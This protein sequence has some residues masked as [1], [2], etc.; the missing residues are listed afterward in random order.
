MKSGCGGTVP[1]V[2]AP[3]VLPRAASGTTMPDVL[4][5]LVDRARVALV[6][7]HRLGLRLHVRD[8][9]RLAGR[10]RALDGMLGDGR[11]ILAAELDHELRL[12]GVDVPRAH[13]AQ[14]A[15]VVEVDGHVAGELRDGD[16][17]ERAERMLDVERRVQQLARARQEAHPAFGDLRLRDVADRR[18][19]RAPTVACRVLDRVR[20]NDRP[21]LLARRAVA[22]ADHA[23]ARLAAQRAAAGKVVRRRAGCR[24][25]RA[26]RSARAPRSGRRRG[27][28]RRSRSR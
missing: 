10:D 5:E 8:E 21:A 12:R 23:L 2:I 18:S 13:A 14:H 9:L 22:V 11:R 19:P 1:N 27:T 15:L 6:V 16:G 26:S 28:R 4:R 3:N 17:R 24:P 7:R 20:A 25:R